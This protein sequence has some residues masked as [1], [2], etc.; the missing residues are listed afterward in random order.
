M[1]KLIWLRL[2]GQWKTSLSKAMAAMK[3]LLQ[4]LLPSCDLRLCAMM[5][6][7]L[8]GAHLAVLDSKHV[9]LS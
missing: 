9:L 3:M 1:Q 2:T 6:A 4:M 5:P 8:D 7:V